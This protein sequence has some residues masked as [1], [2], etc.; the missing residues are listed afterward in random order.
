[1]MSFIN[2]VGSMKSVKWIVGAL[3][4]ILILFG[5]TQLYL[6][7]TREDAV[8]DFVKD[9]QVEQLQQDITIRDTAKDTLNE[10]DRTVTTTD[11]GRQWLLRRPP[12]AGE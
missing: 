9:T 1:M 4:A 11:D 5:A 10:I 6:K 3:A 2:L 7:N 12:R 8:E